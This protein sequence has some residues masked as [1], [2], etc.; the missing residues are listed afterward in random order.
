V[1]GSFLITSESETN[2]TETEH[3]E[4]TEPAD[5]YPE[6]V[7]EPEPVDDYPEP[8]VEPEP[9]IEPT[10]PPALSVHTPSAPHRPTPLPVPQPGP[11]IR[12]LRAR[13]LCD[14]EERTRR[15]QQASISSM[16]PQRSDQ[17][18]GPSPHQGPSSQTATP[19][20]AQPYV[21]N[22]ANPYSELGSELA[23][24][25]R[26]SFTTFSQQIGQQIGQQIA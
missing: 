9:A 26:D 15:Y 10:T 22:P 5:D 17:P 24:A 1:T 13:L 20:P 11:P 25:L 8:V 12:P 21:P 3:I 14:H 16:L 18:S 6:P 19:G 4:P 2:S 23:T 7:V